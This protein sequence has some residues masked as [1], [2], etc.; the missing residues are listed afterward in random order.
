MRNEFY[1]VCELDPITSMP[2]KA[3]L[4]KLNLEWVLDDPTVAS[5]V[6]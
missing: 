4:A 3:K 1:V 5:L 6:G 2:T